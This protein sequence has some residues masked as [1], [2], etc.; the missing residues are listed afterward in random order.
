M[1]TD[2]EDITNSFYLV[3]QDLKANPGRAHRSV[4]VVSRGWEEDGKKTYAEV[5]KDDAFVAR[6]AGSLRQILGLG[7]PVVCAAGNSADESGRQ[8]IDALPMLFQDDATPLINVGAAN[9]DGS[10]R[11]K[12][13]GGSQLTL[14]APGEDIEVPQKTDFVSQTES[15]TSM[16]E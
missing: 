8:N 3:L 14:Y 16:G 10:R 7:V 1:S 2:A 12:S 11:A 13:Q 4:V 9:Y 5:I 15:G 6:H